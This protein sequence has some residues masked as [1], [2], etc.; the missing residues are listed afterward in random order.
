[1]VFMTLT[2][3]LAMLSDLGSAYC[4][5]RCDTSSMANIYSIN[6]THVT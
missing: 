3:S 4:R 5:L 6:D 2:A 1:M